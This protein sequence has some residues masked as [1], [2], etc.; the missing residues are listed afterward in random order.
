MSETRKKVEITLGSFACSVEGYEDPVAPMREILLMMREIMGDAP[1]LSGQDR[2][3]SVTLAQIEGALGE[4]G[5]RVVESGPGTITIRAL[6]D[7]GV[8]SARDNIFAAPEGGDPHLPAGNIFRVATGE[9][10]A[11]PLSTSIFAARR[12]LSIIEDVGR[13][14]LPT[15]LI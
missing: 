9:H 2:V 11:S 15:T 14:T 6:E 3:G 5:G 8:S 1:A 10:A 7:G 12:C 4:G 13:A